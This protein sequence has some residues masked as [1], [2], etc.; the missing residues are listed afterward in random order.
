MGEAGKLITVSVILVI[1][2]PHLDGIIPIKQYM[3]QNNF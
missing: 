3:E 1:R 2:Q